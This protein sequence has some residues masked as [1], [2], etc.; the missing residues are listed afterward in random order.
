MN[1]PVQAESECGDEQVSNGAYSASFRECALYA[2]GAWSRQ[3]RIA[4]ALA[5]RAGIALD[6]ETLL[7]LDVRDLQA[8][9]LRLR[10]VV[11]KPRPLAALR[12]NGV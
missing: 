3:A 9:Q 6:E 8:L 12:E 10:R 4:V 1:M 7:V 2:G 5:A 11:M